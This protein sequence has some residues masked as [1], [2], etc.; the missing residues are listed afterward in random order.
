MIIQFEDCVDIVKT[1]HPDFECVFLFYH[2]C[3]HDRQRQASHEKKQ[4][5]NG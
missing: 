5:G 2:S 3:G 1:L 4:D